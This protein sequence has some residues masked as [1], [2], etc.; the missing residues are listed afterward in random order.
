MSILHDPGRRGAELTIEYFAAENLDLRAERDALSELLKMTLAALHESTER[1]QR[2]RD[3]IRRL[4]DE[5]RA[6]RREL[7]TLR[8][9]R[10]A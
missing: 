9:R 3:M 7:L 1:E 10:A 2:H 6:L 4:C 5:L 8:D